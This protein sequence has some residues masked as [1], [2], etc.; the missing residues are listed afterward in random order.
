MK[1]RRGQFVAELI[2]VTAV[3]TSTSVIIGIVIGFLTFIGT[4]VNSKNMI[5]EAFLPYLYPTALSPLNADLMI[6]MARNFICNVSP[7]I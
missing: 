5:Y 7:I 4:N 3:E 1:W 2:T 6:D